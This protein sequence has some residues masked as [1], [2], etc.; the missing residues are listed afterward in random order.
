[1]AAS[2][3]Q[4]VLRDPERLTLD[5]VSLDII[6]FLLLCSGGKCHADRD[7]KMS[8]VRRARAYDK[9]YLL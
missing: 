4:R 3:R 2:A 5:L 7:K 8:Y 1:M 6:D 9:I